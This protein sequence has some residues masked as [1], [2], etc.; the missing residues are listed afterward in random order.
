MSARARY[1][2]KNWDAVLEKWAATLDEAFN[3]YPD[4]HPVTEALNAVMLSIG[5]PEDYSEKV[6]TY[7]HIAADPDNQPTVPKRRAER[8][9]QSNYDMGRPRDRSGETRRV[10]CCCAGVF[11]GHSK[12]RCSTKRITPSPSPDAVEGPESDSNFPSIP[13][14]IQ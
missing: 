9:Q 8:G 7:L 3:E 12:G 1:S 2:E 11:R 4:G 10:P 13:K 6:S 14:G 5:D